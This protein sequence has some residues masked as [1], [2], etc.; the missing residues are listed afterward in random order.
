MDF[1]RLIE[2]KLEEK[3]MSKQAL[4]KKISETFYSNNGVKQISYQS[5]VT[6]IA[7]NKLS[8]VDFFEIAEILSINTKE[9]QRN[10]HMKVLEDSKKITAQIQ[11][12]ILKNSLF[13]NENTEYI[14]SHPD[15][16][17][18]YFFYKTYLLCIDGV[19]KRVSLELFDF[20][21]MKVTTIADVSYKQ[22]YFDDEDFNAFLNMS[23][24]S[25]LRYLEEINQFASDLYPNK[26]QYKLI[27]D[28]IIPEIDW[29]FDYSYTDVDD[30]TSRLKRLYEREDVFSEFI[31]NFENKFKDD[32]SAFVENVERTI[33]VEGVGVIFNIVSSSYYIKGNTLKVINNIKINNLVK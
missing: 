26:P 20:L 23:Q 33:D 27:R 7:E 28:I 15:K 4:Y 18:N 6:R 25:K 17:S 10:I 21:D 22:E 8:A 1:T 14:F 30:I 31:G 29:E 3:N 2:K 32:T 5:F 24:E 11:G 16:E 13:F 19:K 9:I 12:I